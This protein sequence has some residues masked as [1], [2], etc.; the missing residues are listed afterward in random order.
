M[1]QH[2]VDYSF[3]EHEVNVH[4]KFRITF[5]ANTEEN[6]PWEFQ[7]KTPTLVV[8]AGETALCFY[9]VMNRSDKPIAGIAIYQITPE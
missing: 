4:R 2:A 5:M 9:Q 6:I 7:P 3:N 1:R 8:N